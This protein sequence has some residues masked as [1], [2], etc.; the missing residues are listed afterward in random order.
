MNR[1]PNAKS[2][3]RSAV[4]VTEAGQE[5]E[6]GCGGQG[7]FTVSVVRSDKEGYKWE[8]SV[9]RPLASGEKLL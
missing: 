3:V 7:W 9:T 6:E 5:S 4:G 1:W 2:C 8:A